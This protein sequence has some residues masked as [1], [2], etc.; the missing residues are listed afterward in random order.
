MAEQENNKRK[1]LAALQSK[2]VLVKAATLA[3][4]TGVQKSVVNSVLYSEA[5]ST[6]LPRPVLVQ[7]DGSPH[8]KMENSASAEVAPHSAFLG[9]NEY[10]KNKVKVL[11]AL[12]RRSAPVQAKALA[13]ETGVLKS[14]VNKILYGEAKSAGYPRP[15]LVQ[16]QR[17]P[18]WTMEDAPVVVREEPAASDDAPVVVREEPAASDDTLAE[19]EPWPCNEKKRIKL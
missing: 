11:E 9:M 13:D 17:T 16:N 12:R 4:E 15:V 14:V 3:S 7:V 19:C 10:N 18:H 2:S 5:N 6:N 8:W 1:I